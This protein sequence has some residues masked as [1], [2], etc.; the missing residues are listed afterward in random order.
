VGEYGTLPDPRIVLVDGET[1]QELDRW[2][3]ERA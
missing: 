1:G 2:P 3:Q